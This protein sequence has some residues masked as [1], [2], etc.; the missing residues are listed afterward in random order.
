MPEK[1]SILIVD[2]DEGMLETLSDILKEK[3]YQTETAKTGIEAIIKVRTRFFDVALID[4]R[5]PDLTGIELLRT[6]REEHPSMVSIIITGHSTT[7]N[8]VEA[9]NLGANAYITKPIDHEKL[10]SII[11]K[12]LAQ[13]HGL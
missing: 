1:T 7:Q 5:L 12:R 11:K 2:D 4:I 6:F 10:D 13:A 8:A 3:G 9:L